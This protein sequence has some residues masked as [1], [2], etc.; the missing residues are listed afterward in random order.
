MDGNLSLT[1]KSAELKRSVEMGIER[2]YLKE[3]KDQGLKLISNNGS[4]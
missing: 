3:M 1:S 2:E 4:R